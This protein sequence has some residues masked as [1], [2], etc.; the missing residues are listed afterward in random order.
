MALSPRRPACVSDQSLDGQVEKR[1]GRDLLD[2]THPLGSGSRPPP[3]V[4]REGVARLFE[5]R[6]CVVT[7]C[8]ETSAVETDQTDVN[9]Q[10]VVLRWASDKVSSGTG[11][12]YVD[13]TIPVYQNI[14]CILR[15]EQTETEKVAS[16]ERARR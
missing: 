6:V 12:E 1:W 3:D 5:V 10:R 13:W 7:F 14:A 15:G 4:Q 9:S 16:N 2:M 8:R 11:R